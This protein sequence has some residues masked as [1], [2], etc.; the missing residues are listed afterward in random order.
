MFK[1]VTKN[2]FWIS[3]FFYPEH[4]KTFLYLCWR[5]VTMACHCLHGGGDKVENELLALPLPSTPPPYSLPSV[6]NFENIFISLHPQS[7]W[8]ASGPLPV[9]AFPPEWFLL[10]FVFS[11][12]P[13][14]SPKRHSTSVTQQSPA[15]P[16][17]LDKVFTYISQTPLKKCFIKIVPWWFHTYMSYYNYCHPCHFPPFSQPYYAPPQVPFPHLGL[18]VLFVNPLHMVGAICVT[19]HPWMLSIGFWLIHLWL[20][21]SI[22]Q[23]LYLVYTWFYIPPMVLMPLA[24]NLTELEIS[25]SRT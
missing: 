21:N 20:S 7:V 22:N 17:C 11:L 16:L 25:G 24:L 8:L 3:N 9:M 6:S 2:I 4:F 12:I 5:C 13:T 14:H 23:D 18:C 1:H 10:D 19:M 15:W